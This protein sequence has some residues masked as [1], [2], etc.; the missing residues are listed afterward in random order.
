MLETAVFP[1]RPLVVCMLVRDLKVERFGIVVP[2]FK[3]H[4]CNYF[5]GLDLFIR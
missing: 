2:Q 3:L 1:V 5:V 4:C